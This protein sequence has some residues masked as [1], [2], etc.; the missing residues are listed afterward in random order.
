MASIPR[1]L[2]LQA[3]LA[4]SHNVRSTRRRSPALL[5]VASCS[6][7]ALASPLSLVFDES[8][9]RQILAQFAISDG[10]V[11]ST[12]TPG[13]A[14]HPTDLS[15][16]HAL[17]DVPLVADRSVDSGSLSLGFRICPYSYPTRLDIS[18]LY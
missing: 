6:A 10:I 8:S 2:P 14:R 12:P 11:Q 9:A 13:N 15:T 1:S 4:L 18:W 17:P 5:P 16:T 3:S 7:V